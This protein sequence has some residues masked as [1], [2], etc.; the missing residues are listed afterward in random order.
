MPASRIQPRREAGA[1][2]DDA[3]RR[4]RRE[5]RRSS[6]RRC[7]RI[8]MRIEA[9]CSPRIRVDAYISLNGFVVTLALCP[10][11]IRP[12]TSGRDVL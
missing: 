6:K 10:P 8:N 7:H 4:L 11:V 2:Y 12:V 5:A 3:T 1:F 9:T